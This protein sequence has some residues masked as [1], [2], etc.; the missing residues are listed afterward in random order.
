[1]GEEQTGLD[2]NWLG[3]E[4]VGNCEQGGILIIFRPRGWKRCAF[5]KS[6]LHC[7]SW[8]LP[9]VCLLVKSR[10]HV[11]LTSALG[12]VLRIAADVSPVHC[13]AIVHHTDAW[14]VVWFVT[15]C[16]V[17]TP[18]SPVLQRAPRWRCTRCA[19]ARTRVSGTTAT[20]GSATRST[21][22]ATP[23]APSSTATSSS[24][25]SMTR[26]TISTTC[27]SSPPSGMSTH[28]VSFVNSC[29]FT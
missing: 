20:P 15:L 14:C 6:R 16:N 27:P 5:Q 17:I 18:I 4:S 2:C 7:H 12:L 3:H 28:V 26:P 29:R 25:F 1:M 23:T 10:D 22:G 19:G 9:K 8:A 21:S 11:M 24:S 13:R